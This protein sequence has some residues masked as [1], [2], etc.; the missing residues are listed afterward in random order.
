MRCLR[1]RSKPSVSRNSKV[2]GILSIPKGFNFVAK[3]R[4]PHISPYLAFASSS[5]PLS[6]ILC[7]HYP[8]TKSSRSG[9]SYVEKRKL[10]NYVVV[11]WI[12]TGFLRICISI[13]PYFLIVHSY[14]TV[15]VAPCYNAFPLML[16]FPL[17]T[18]VW[19]CGSNRV[20]FV[21]ELQGLRLSIK[22]KKNLINADS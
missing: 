8:A 22:S 20:A 17:K 5:P 12:L 18:Y 15:S 16:N 4:S 19:N 1:T 7:I 9:A 21:S 11:A 10:P 13:T 14:V 6:A 2:W 3:T